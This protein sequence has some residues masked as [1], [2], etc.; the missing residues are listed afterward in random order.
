MGNN[1]NRRDKIKK[2]IQLSLLLVLCCIPISVITGCGGTN[3]YTPFYA[4]GTDADTMIDYGS[5][6]CPAGCIGFGCNTVCFPTE[7]LYVNY[8]VGDGSEN[9]T[10]L[11]YYYD[12]FGCLDNENV[13]S[14]GSYTTTSNCTLLSA[15]YSKGYTEDVSKSLVKST[16]S[17]SCFGCRLQSQNV[18]SRNLNEIMPR[19]YPYGC[20][21]VC[22]EEE[23]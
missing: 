8:N 23:K 5:C 14:S 7:C 22:H 19:Q 9:T 16:Y 18:E 11:I 20:Y 12:D 1:K 2:L 17:T 3:C 13:M 10:G 4:G 6:V 21:T 15:L